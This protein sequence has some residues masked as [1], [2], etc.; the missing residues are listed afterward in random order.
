MCACGVRFFDLIKKGLR[1]VRRCKKAHYVVWGGR[2]V[3]INIFFVLTVIVCP[4]FAESM[5]GETS[6]QARFFS[7]SF[8]Q[9]LLENFFEKLVH[10]S[11]AGYVL[12]GEKPLYVNNYCDEKYA[13]TGTKEHKEIIELVE[14]GDSCKNFKHFDADYFLH[15]S[16]KSRNEL[17]VINKNSLINVINKNKS[18]FQYKLGVNVTAEG[19]LKQLIDSRETI[20]TLIQK[21]FLF[22]WHYVGIW[23]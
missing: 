22:A 20:S 6:Q 1:S 13:C 18:L 21:Q 8:E 17:L 16:K 12:Y 19:L 14:V 2:I 10:S 7:K 15:I 5:E 11:T 9:Q 4:L 23:N 3:F